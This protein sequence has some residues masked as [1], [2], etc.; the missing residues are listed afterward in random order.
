MFKIS[1]FSPLF[2]FVLLT[3]CS[4][5]TPQQIPT[6]TVANVSS[7]ATIQAAYAGCIRDMTQGLINDVSVRRST[8]NPAYST[9]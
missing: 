7:D 8:P 2:L 1:T 4:D 3:A 9:A 5:N 6:L